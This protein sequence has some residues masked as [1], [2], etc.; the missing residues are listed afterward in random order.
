MASIISGYKYDVFISYRQKDNKYDGWVTEFVDNLKGE[1][2]STFKEEINVYFDINPHDGLLETHDVDASLKDKLKCLV[3]IPIISRTYCDP[4]SFAW[5]HEFKAFIDLASQDKLGMKVKLP[6]GN[7]ASRVLPVR[8][9]DLDKDDMNLCESV[10]GGVLRGVEFIYKEPGVNKP[11]TAEDDE[12]KNLNNTKYRI[13]INKVALSINEIIRGLKKVNRSALEKAEKEI[14]ILLDDNLVNEKPFVAQFPYG[15]KTASNESYH[16]K[17]NKSIGRIVTLSSLVII[18]AIMTLFLFSSGSTLPFSKRD[19]IVIADFENLTG[20]PVFDKSLY[21]AFTLTT[22][23]S[24]YINVFPRSR[25]IETLARMQIND[26]T[27][28][29]DKKSK[30]IAIR[31]GI[32]IYVV[33]GI[34]QV[35]KMYVITTKITEAKTEKLLKSEILYASTQDEILT[36]LD[37]LSKKLR[38]DLGESRFRVTTQNKPL[39]KVTTSS[40]EALKQYSLGIEHHSLL[41]FDGTKR[42]YENALRIDTGFTSAKASLGTLLFEKFDTTEG[43]KLLIQAVRSIDHLTNREKYRILSSYEVYVKHDINSGIENTKILIDL[44]PDDSDAHNSLG[45]YYQS[46]GQYEEAVKEDKSAL[47]INPNLALTNAALI[48]IYLDMLGKPDSALVWSE[49][50]VTYN[51]QNAWSYFDLGSALLCKDSLS[52]AK[53]AFEKASDLNPNFILNLY[54]LSHTYRI[55]GNYNE[56]IGILKKIPEIDKN[57][58]S[59][60]YDIGVNYQSMGNLQEARKFFS[61]YKK[62]I[63]EEL[64]KKLPDDAGPYIDMSEVMARLGEMD[65]SR[66]MLQKAIEIDSTLHY[67]FAEVYC[68]QGNSPEALNQLGKAFNKGYRDLFWLK[69]TPD[70]QILHY[71]TRF[72][73]LMK[74]FFK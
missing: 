50:M 27:S 11:L 10:L 51:P 39:S 35:G 29:D 47:R 42:Y 59:A 33:P 67:R 7:V 28:I 19:W 65:S 5:E 38:R 40:L 46:S 8:I 24:S 58:T 57:E 25:M 31:E 9:H 43:R 52:K 74:K 23:Q 14:N 12:K 36:K 71:D 20:N 73:D 64:M 6:S 4:K 41:D 49:K 21:T 26:L 48:W 32:N 53:T 34:S 72:R 16:G 63:A 69:L 15:K 3:F 54:R 2:E 68:L 1:L 70:L 17:S 13:Q 45:W 66:Q 30:E 37:Q 61:I 60:F 44:Y 18:L 22:N 56:A 55:Q 62:I